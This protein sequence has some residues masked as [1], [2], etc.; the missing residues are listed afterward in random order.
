MGLHIG[1]DEL[2]YVA[3]HTNKRVQVLQSDLSFIRSIMVKCQSNVQSVS[4]DST[5]NIHVGTGGGIVEIFSSVGQYIGQYS[6]GIIRCVGD[7]TFMRNGDCV[8]VMTYEIPMVM[9]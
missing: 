3:D 9:V 1:K 4:T 5:G 6:S 2:L 7:I 8:V